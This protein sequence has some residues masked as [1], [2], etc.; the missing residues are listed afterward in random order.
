[1]RTGR[2]VVIAALLGAE[3]YGFGTLPL[4]A[5]GCKMVRQCHENTCPVGIATQREDLRAKYTGAVEQVVQLFRLIAEDVRRH[6][7]AIGASTLDEI[8]GRADLLEPVV[9]HPMAQEFSELLARADFNQEHSFR[10]YNRSPVG[11]QLAVEG[12]R[13]ARSGRSID[14]AYPVGNTDRSI[15]TRLSGEIAELTGDAGLPPETIRVRLAG[16]AGQSFG[17]FLHKGISLRLSGTANDYVGKGMGGG[18][19]VVKPEVEDP[20]ATPHGGGNACLYGATGGKLFVSG[21]VGQRFAV[22]NSGAVAVVEGASDHC[23]EYMT[24]GAVAVVGPVRR[25]VAAG[26]TG[27]VLFVW[28]PDLSAEQHFAASAPPASRLAAA[29]AAQLRAM[30]EEHVAETQSRK[31]RAILDRWDQA[32]GEFWVVRALPPGSPE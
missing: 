18:L 8:I 3:R 31:V 6:L 32:V 29:D 10:D 14:L 25:N 1:M 28:D 9:D 2:D 22:R 24:G 7:A 17:A 19:I 20:E 12:R 30:L 21:Q 11:E 15:G 16:T 4:I 26:M 5:L 27:G 13:A 23:A